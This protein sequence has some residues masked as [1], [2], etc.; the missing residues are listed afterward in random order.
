MT[1]HGPDPHQ[2]HPLPELDDGRTLAI[3]DPPPA[4]PT[5]HISAAG[6]SIRAPQGRPGDCTGTVRIAR[7]KD[8]R[9]ATM[10]LGPADD[11]VRRRQSERAALELARRDPLAPAGGPVPSPDAIA[12]GSGDFWIRPTCA[13]CSTSTAGFDA[14]F[15]I[16]AQNAGGEHRRRAERPPAALHEQQPGVASSTTTIPSRLQNVAAPATTA[17]SYCHLGSYTP[18]FPT[19]R[20]GLRLSRG[21][22]ST[23]TRRGRA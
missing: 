8:A 11:A 16:V 4:I 12:R 7:L 15:P 19:L 23:C 10:P 13:S 21:A 6:T 20:E 18:A 9:T 22:T 14:L 2:R 3:T 17:N 1:L 5:V